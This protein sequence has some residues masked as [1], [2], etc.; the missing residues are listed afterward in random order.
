MNWALGRK[1]AVAGVAAAVLLATIPVWF[2]LGTEFTPEFDEGSLLY[3][4]TTMPTI[5]V[6]EAQH[7]L[8]LTDR[9]L[10]Q[11]PEVEHV[12][13]K[14]GRAGTSTDSAPLSMLET[15]VILKPMEQWRGRRRGIRHGRQ[16]G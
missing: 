4:P 6:D 7:I 15:V 14:A 13:G 12:L 16:T 1:V 8:Q 10:K 3:M 9:I 5:P 2:S 11:F